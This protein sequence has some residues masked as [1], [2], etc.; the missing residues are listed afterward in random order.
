M[1]SLLLSSSALGSGQWA[2]SGHLLPQEEEDGGLGAAVRQPG[3]GRLPLL[4]LLLPA[5][6]HVLLSP[7]LAGRKH[8]VCVLRTWLL[9]LWPVQHVHHHRHQHHPLPEDVLQP[10]LW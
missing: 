1:S 2:G 10:G 3:R 6:H 9:H 8:H 7:C 5:L 4:H